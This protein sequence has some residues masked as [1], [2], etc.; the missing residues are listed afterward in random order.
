LTGSDV[1]R[2]LVADQVRAAAAGDQRAFDHL[3]DRY[4][5]MVWSVLRAHR[6]GDADAEDAFQTTWLRLVEHLDRI[7]EP[8]AVGGW[9]ATTARNES[10]R[11]LRRADRSR[12]VPDEDLDTVDER[13]EQGETTVL[14]AERDAALWAAYEELEER[15][16]RLLRV[17]MAD[18]P[19]SYEE[20]SAA[21][22]LPIGSIGPTRGRCLKR[23]RTH[24]RARGISDGPADSG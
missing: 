12:P 20:V 11:L 13:V 6:L 21:L 17:L 18:P 22:D 1:D 24:L 16:R 15:C 5:G 7:R 19:P 4:A 10:L 23:L 14:V 9:L 8:R 3:V 2:A